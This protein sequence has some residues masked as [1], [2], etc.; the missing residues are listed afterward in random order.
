[1]FLPAGH[2]QYGMHRRV[3]PLHSMRTATVDGTHLCH[4]S[5]VTRY[6]TVWANTFTAGNYQ[7]ISFTGDQDFNNPWIVIGRGN[8]GD[9]DVYART[10]SSQVSL[11]VPPGWMHLIPPHSMAGQYQW[12]WIYV[13]GILV[14]L[15]TITQTVSTNMMIQISDYL[16]AVP[17]LGRLDKGNTLPAFRQ[18]YLSGVFDA[19]TQKL[20]SR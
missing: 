15:F 6:I 3:L 16:P 17:R 9:N 5:V 12:I 2:L 13:D 20:G 8:A 18:F 4:N 11:I 10:N 1:M 14:P 19:G 7:N